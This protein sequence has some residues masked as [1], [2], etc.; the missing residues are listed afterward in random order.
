MSITVPERVWWKPL[1]KGEKLWVAIA[2][3]WCLVMFIMMPLWHLQ[4]KQN[5]PSE[6]Y[7][8]SAD[9][10]EKAA[11][12]FITQ[13]R[14]GEEQGVPVV[15]P[16]SGSDI[17]LVAR[18]WSWEPVLKL[19]KGKT[20][21]LHLSSV[22]LQHGMTIYPMNINF[23]VLPGYDYVLTITPTEK[24]EYHLICNEFCGIGHHLMVGKILVV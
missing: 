2:L 24:G 23:Q 12:A 8:V 21:R 4:G 11:A 13:Y 3:T 20:Y 17:Y 16:P 5:A 15:A 9:Q 7:R 1:D 10:F 18:M 14:V 6:T 19:E 22:D